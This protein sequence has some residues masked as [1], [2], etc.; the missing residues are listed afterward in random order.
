MHVLTYIKYFDLTCEKK[1]S[2]LSTQLKYKN[3]T[4]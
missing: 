3:F 1:V 2:I 4:F